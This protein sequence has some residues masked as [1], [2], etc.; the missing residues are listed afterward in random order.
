MIEH[1]LTTEDNPF[2]PVTQ[3]DE[4]LQW[5]IDNGYNTLAYLGRV[6]V[7][8]DDLSPADQSQAIET[9]I[10]E[11]VDLNITGNYK[12]IPVTS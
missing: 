7:T 11:I 2:D 9:A 6:V 8:S 4:W 10:D 12:K 1:M 5:D 3:W